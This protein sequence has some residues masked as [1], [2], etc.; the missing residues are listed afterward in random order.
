[1]LRR[2]GIRWRNFNAHAV[3]LDHGK[4]IKSSSV[5]H[6]LHFTYQIYTFAF[7]A[8]H[9][10]VRIKFDAIKLRYETVRYKRLQIF[11]IKYYFKWTGYRFQSV[12]QLGRTYCSHMSTYTEAY[13]WRLGIWRTCASVQPQLFNL[14]FCVRNW[15]EMWQPISSPKWEIEWMATAIVFRLVWCGCALRGLLN[16]MFE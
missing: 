15:K 7:V 10:S 4:V 11:D 16:R 5:S 9:S 3:W 12:Q 6:A 1:M 2:C 14:M 13:A 8:L